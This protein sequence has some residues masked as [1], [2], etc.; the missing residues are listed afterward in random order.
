MNQ[1][2]GRPI[3]SGIG[4]P[5]EKTRKYMDKCI[6]HLVME[7]PSFVLD[8]AN[9]LHRLK[10]LTIPDDCIQA[11]IDVE[12]LYSAISHQVGVHAASQWLELRHPLAGPQSEI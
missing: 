2:P 9:I 7:L 3:V 11:G 8:S 12:A 6:K 4:G 10:D 1:P 5:L